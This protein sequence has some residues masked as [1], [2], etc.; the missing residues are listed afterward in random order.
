MA[1]FCVLNL[2]ILINVSFVSVLYLGVCFCRYLLQL[3]TEAGCLEWALILAIL[4]HDAMAVVRTTAAARAPSQS[5]TCV[6]RLRDTV[7]TLTS[8]SNTEW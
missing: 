7:T 2:V 3:M 6:L 5:Y 8:W 4:L 1:D